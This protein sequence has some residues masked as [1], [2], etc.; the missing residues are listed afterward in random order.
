MEYPI[1]VSYEKNQNPT[2]FKEK[3]NFC[4]TSDGKIVL[5]KEIPKRNNVKNVYYPFGTSDVE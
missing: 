2:Q 4:A 1:K 3:G 5:D